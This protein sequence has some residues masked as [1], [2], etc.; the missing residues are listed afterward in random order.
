MRIKYNSRCLTLGN[1]RV[2]STSTCAPADPKQQW[3]MFADG[4]A[5]GFRNLGNNGASAS[6]ASSPALDRH[7]R[8]LRRQRQ[9][10]LEARDLHPRRHR[11]E[12]PLRMHNVAENF[13][14]YT[15]LTG[16][17]YGTIANCDLLGT[18]DN[19]KVGLY[20]GGAFNQPPLKP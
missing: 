9:A 17:T 1:K 10:A 11:P 12:L 13:C 18:Q 14:I 7:H 20:P 6:P 4:T 8:P 15:D 2:E 3:K 5:F 16:L 19:R